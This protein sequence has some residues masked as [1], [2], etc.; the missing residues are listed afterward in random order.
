[1][2]ELHSFDEVFDGQKVFRSILEAMSNP[3]RR[4]SIAEQAAKMSGDNGTF[5]AIAMTLL[6]NEVSFSTCE[7]QELSAEIELLTLSKETSMDAADFIFVEK[8]EM[9]PEIFEKAKIGTL[10]D[11]QKSA[12]IIIKVEKA[13]DTELNLYGAGI[14][15]MW[16]IEMP[17][18]VKTA[19][20]LR[21]AQNYEYPQGVDMM[22][23]TN[24]GEIFCIPRLVLN[25]E[26]Q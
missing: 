20:D 25:K 21:Q 11:P 5:L 26:A 18:I 22:F 1:M 3:G 8:E 15:G 17:E 9:L 24:A 13:S 6:D 10:E 23:V 16:K 12:S 14:K 2:K 7:N 19:I 4:V